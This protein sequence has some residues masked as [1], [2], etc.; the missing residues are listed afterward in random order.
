MGYAL[1]AE[2]NPRSDA[3]ADGAVHFHSASSVHLDACQVAAGESTFEVGPLLRALLAGPHPRALGHSEE[4][5]GPFT[6]RL[7]ARIAEVL[8]STPAAKSNHG[9]LRTTIHVLSM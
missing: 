9:R 3:T 5:F 8:V 6:D 7:A 1:R 2:R 4:Y